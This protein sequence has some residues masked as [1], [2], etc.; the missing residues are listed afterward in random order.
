MPYK[1]TSSHSYE[2][3]EATTDKNIHYHTQNQLYASQ[4]A[5]KNSPS[6]HYFS[7]GLQGQ[8]VPQVSSV[9]TQVIYFFHLLKI[10]KNSATDVGES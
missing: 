2:V 6:A 7:T 8:Y 9:K 3:T 4:Q 1:I 10:T 5:A